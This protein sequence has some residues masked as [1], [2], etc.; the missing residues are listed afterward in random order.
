MTLIILIFLSLSISFWSKIFL[1]TFDIGLF[2]LEIDI[3]EI[4]FPE[5]VGFDIFTEEF[6][7]KKLLFDNHL[8]D[9]VDEIV[10]LELSRWREILRVFG[11]GIVNSLANNSQ[12]IS[13][14]RS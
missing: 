3:V 1:Y 2:I 14:L 12:S 7:D 11:V 10:S 6:I 5:S 13:I 8:T 9:V 4:S